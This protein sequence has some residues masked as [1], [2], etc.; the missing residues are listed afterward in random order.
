MARHVE[1]AAF[2]PT[3][4][5]DS[6][7]GILISGLR[8]NPLPDLVRGAAEEVPVQEKRDHDKTRPSTE[9]I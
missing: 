4:L 6:E 1:I 3:H 8:R 7:R 9:P 5:L 2:F